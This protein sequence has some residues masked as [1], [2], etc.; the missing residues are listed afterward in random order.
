MSEGRVALPTNVDAHANTRNVI[1]K[2]VS[3]SQNSHA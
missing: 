3:P 1:L 2:A